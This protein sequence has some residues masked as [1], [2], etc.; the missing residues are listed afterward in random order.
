[1]EHAR[2]ELAFIRQLRVLVRCETCSKNQR[3]SLRFHNSNFAPPPQIRPFSISP[4]IH[5]EQSL[6][7]Q[8]AMD[9]RRFKVNHRT[10]QSRHAPARCPPR[11]SAQRQET[12]RLWSSCC[13]HRGSVDQSSLLQVSARAVTFYLHANV[14]N[15]LA[16]V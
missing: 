1:M 11:R 12:P 2:R 5:P 8:D 16:N 10:H 15:V 3:S 13:W 7:P 6:S 9:R 14:L 4:V